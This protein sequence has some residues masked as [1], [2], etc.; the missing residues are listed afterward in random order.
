MIC[1]EGNGGTVTRVVLDTARD[2]PTVAYDLQVRSLSEDTLKEV[3][4]EEVKAIRHQ[5]SAVNKLLDA[6]NNPLWLSN[7]IRMFYLPIW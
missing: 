1:S 4:M 6:H 7:R 2:H 5:N 3:W